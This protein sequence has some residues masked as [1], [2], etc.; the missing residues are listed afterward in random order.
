MASIFSFNSFA[1]YGAEIAVLLS[2]AGVVILWRSL[3]LQDIHIREQKLVLAELRTHLAQCTRDQI[4]SCD[5]IVALQEQCSGLQ[6]RQQMLEKHGSDAQRIDLAMRM[7]KRGSRDTATLQDLGLSSS[8][9]K[10]LLRLHSKPE[11]AQS[12]VNPEANFTKAAK[13]KKTAELV[14]DE[15]ST[16]GQALAQL[17]KT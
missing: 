1:G 15:V 11:A 6:A 8:E 3:A 13:N 9:I 12:V 2:L 10:L 4:E 7:L 14:P 16:Q 5:L 17:F